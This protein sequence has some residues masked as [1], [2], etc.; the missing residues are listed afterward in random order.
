[1]LFSGYFL[2]KITGT[3]NPENKLCS[4]SSN[5]AGERLVKVCALE[6]CTIIPI[7]C[8]LFVSQ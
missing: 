5:L 4:L 7:M 2:S 3:E 1:M 6:N 8:I